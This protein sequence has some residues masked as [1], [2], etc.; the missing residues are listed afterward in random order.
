MSDPSGDCPLLHVDMDAFYA[1]VAV[2]DSPELARV[3]MTRARGMC[4]DAVVLDPEYA[5]LQRARIRL[6]GVRV[7]GLVPRGS[8]HRQLVLGAPEHGWPDADRAVDRPVSRFGRE[9][10]QP[11]ALLRGHEK[12]RT[13]VPQ[14]GSPA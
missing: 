11:A 3:S 2:R 5:G 4:P 10:V 13:R 6:V 7:E 14:G 12:L 8:V 1:S 9:A